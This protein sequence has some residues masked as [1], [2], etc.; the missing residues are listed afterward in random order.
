MTSCDL[1]T[2]SVRPVQFVMQI[3]QQVWETLPARVKVSFTK[4]KLVQLWSF[5]TQLNE[6]CRA[7][8]CYNSYLHIS[9]FLFYSCYEVNVCT[10]AMT[11]ILFPIDWTLVQSTVLVLSFWCSLSSCAVSELWLLPLVSVE[12]VCSRKSSHLNPEPLKK[13]PTLFIV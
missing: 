6:F 12:F 2:S 13:L 3:H 1:C 5:V 11:E 10:I 8:E 7:Y 9:L 4:K